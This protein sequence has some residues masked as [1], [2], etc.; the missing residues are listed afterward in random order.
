M[1][2]WLFTQLGHATTD[3]GLDALAPL[4]EQQ[5]SGTRMFLE[6]NFRWRFP[7]FDTVAN[8]LDWVLRNIAGLNSWPEFPNRIVH[9]DPVHP[10]WYIVW[11]RSPVWFAAII[12]KLKLALAPILGAHIFWWVVGGVTLYSV[13]R[14]AV[15]PGPIPGPGPTLPTPTP[16][17]VPAISGMMEGMMSIMMIVMLFGMLKR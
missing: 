10:V 4:E 6:I 8:G 2:E 11:M 12:A 15:E 5:H 9:V 16:T 3:G 7:G 17:P 13:F 1:S 14:T